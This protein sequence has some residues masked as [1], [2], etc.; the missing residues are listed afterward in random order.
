M[1]Q[2]DL[3]IVADPGELRSGIIEMV[4]SLGIRVEVKPIEVGDYL[5]S[6]RTCVERKTAQDLV[7]S[8]KTK[9]LFKQILELGDNYKR[10][11]LLIEGYNLY[12][13]KG[14]HAPGIRGA[15][16]LITVSHGIPVI[17]TQDKK[18]TA[19]YLATICRQEHDLRK[20]I[21]LHPKRKALSPS[22][23]IERIVGS[24]PGVGPVLTRQLLTR[25]R[26]IGEFLS[27]SIED[28]QSVPMVGEKKAAR[29]KEI[30]SR[31]YNPEETKRI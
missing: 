13:A 1:E 15:L 27:A 16:T 11:L 5:I 31:K 29:I 20:P 4:R 23:E 10:P 6:E 25:Y 18:D 21:S 3:L 12:E 30:L 28:L 22:D 19:Q 17:F 26:T 24:F 8:I 2:S 7:A 9:R 14:V